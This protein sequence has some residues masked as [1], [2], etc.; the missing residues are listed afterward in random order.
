LAYLAFLAVK[1]GVLMNKC[2]LTVL[3]AAGILIA[4]IFFN[5]G[6]K[7]LKHAAASEKAIATGYP[8]TLLTGTVWA[9]I[10]PVLIVG[11]LLF[12]TFRKRQK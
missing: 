7:L 10:L 9:Y 11:A 1:V 2:Q 4:G 8:F 6:L 5:T 3:W 12:V